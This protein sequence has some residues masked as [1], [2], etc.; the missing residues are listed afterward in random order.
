MGPGMGFNWRKQ[1]SFFFSSTFLI[2]HLPSTSQKIMSNKQW[3]FVS[4]F[5]SQQNHFIFWSAPVKAILKEK[6]V[7][8]VVREEDAAN[9]ASDRV[10]I[11]SLET[12]AEND[13]DEGLV[14]DVGCSVVLHELGEIWFLRVVAH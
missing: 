14:M 12:R 6:G 10:A 13:T 2:I 3:M 11:N 4:P 9:S 5:K 8:R 7:C 1:R